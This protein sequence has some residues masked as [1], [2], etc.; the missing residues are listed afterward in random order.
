MSYSVYL[1]IYTYDINTHRR[2]PSSNRQIK[3]KHHCPKRHETHSTQMSY[4]WNSNSSMLTCESDSLIFTPRGCCRIT[5]SSDGR[6]RLNEWMWSSSLQVSRMG[7]ILFVG[8]SCRNGWE[9]RGEGRNF[10]NH[11][12]NT[13]PTNLKPKR[14]PQTE[15]QLPLVC[16]WVSSSRYC[17]ASHTD[18]FV[19]QTVSFRHRKQFF[20]VLV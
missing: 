18:L 13:H 15:I 9:Q 20:T 1:T 10:A 8:N 5:P 19:L 6:V 11:W 12:Q 17:F 3:R 14:P 4:H 16:S 2:T 7:V